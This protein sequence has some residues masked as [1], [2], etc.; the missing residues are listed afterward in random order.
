MCLGIPMRIVQIRGEEATVDSGGLRRK[1]GLHLVKNVR[2]GDY[3]IVHAGFAIEKLNK[4]NAKETLALLKEI[5]K[6]R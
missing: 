1:I 6:P 4:K 5:G 2:I 3:V